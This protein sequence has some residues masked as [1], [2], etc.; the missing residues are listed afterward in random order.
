MFLLIPSTNPRKRSRT[1]LFHAQFFWETLIWTGKL[2]FTTA[3]VDVN[4]LFLLVLGILVP[5]KIQMI[6]TLNE[7]EVP[8]DV[9]LT[10]QLFRISRSEFGRRNEG[11]PTVSKLHAIKA[12]SLW[13]C[14][15]APPSILRT[16]TLTLPQIAAALVYVWIKQTGT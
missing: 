16:L 10:F 14:H 1:A 12:V 13:R 2:N 11:S 15:A 5:W 3:L 7:C 9:I 4:S 6:E 8:C